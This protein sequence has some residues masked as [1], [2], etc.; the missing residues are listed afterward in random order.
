MPLVDRSERDLVDHR[1]IADPLRADRAVALLS[2]GHYSLMLTARGSGR[3]SWNGLEVTRWRPDPTE[4][5]WGGF[6]FLR[7]I[8]DG[9]WWSATAEP[10]QAE[11]EIAQ[12][13]VSDSKVE[14]HKRVGTLRSQ[15][16]VL[17]ASDHDAEGRRLTLT[18][19]GKRDRIIE[20]TSYAEPVLFRPEADAAHPAFARMFLR[21]GIDAPAGVIH[22]E[23]RPRGP[24]EPDMSV[25]HMIVTGDTAEGAI[26]A[27]T[28][29][30]AFIGRGRTLAGAAAFDPGATLSGADGFTLDPVLSLRRRI[31]VPAGK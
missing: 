6:V 10:R 16:D 18:N 31:R 8:E 7:D 25:A 12:T 28:D 22:V 26:E 5:R 29:R 30:R 23:R 4:D 17:V 20:V 13:V 11:G 21:T 15:M 24:G 9:A 1:V 3:A 2:N 14:F 27:E 19:E